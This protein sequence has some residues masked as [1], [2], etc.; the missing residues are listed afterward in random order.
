MYHIA[1]L[2]K[3]Y[4]T[5]ADLIDEF[6]HNENLSVATLANLPEDFVARKISYYN[7]AYTFMPTLGMLQH[8]RSH[9][10]QMQEAIRIAREE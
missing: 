5:V 3:A 2:A 6:K 4:P 8:T 9:Y 7:L 1:A 10:T